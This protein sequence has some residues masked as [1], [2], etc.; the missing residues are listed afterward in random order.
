V[1]KAEFQRLIDSDELLEWAIVYE[2]FYGTSARQIDAI[3][4]GGDDVLLDV[5]VQ[6]ARTIK[7]KRPDAATVFILPPSYQTLRN[8]LES[9]QEDKM[10]VIEQRLRIACNEIKSYANYDY[11]IINEN[12]GRS[13]EELKA[14]IVSERCRREARAEL[15]ES[16]VATFGGLDAESA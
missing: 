3:L 1:D 8:R 13:I 2:N 7:S 11:L 4:A 6:G 12:L 16:I 10:Y 5:D 15:A 14:I 9:R